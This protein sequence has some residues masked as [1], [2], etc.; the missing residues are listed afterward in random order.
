M[1]GAGPLTHDSGFLA[2]SPDP[3]DVTASRLMS[4]TGASA[5]ATRI[6]L[7]TA[8]ASDALRQR[9]LGGRNEAASTLA[10]HALDPSQFHSPRANTEAATHSDSIPQGPS[11][12][13]LRD[14]L[15][16]EFCSPSGPSSVSASHNRQGMYRNEMPPHRSQ[17]VRATPGTHSGTITPEYSGREMAPVQHQHTAPV[18]QHSLESV[19]RS[20]P[21]PAPSLATAVPAL[22]S[23][24]QLQS[25]SSAN[26]FQS[27]D[28]ESLRMAS[29]ASGSLVTIPITTVPQ[30]HAHETQQQAPGRGTSSQPSAMPERSQE[31]GSTTQMHAGVE[32][33]ARGEP[34]RPAVNNAASSQTPRPAIPPPPLPCVRTRPQTRTPSPLPPR[35]AANRASGTRGATSSHASSRHSGHAA[36]TATA[37]DAQKRRRQGA[38]SYGQD[39]SAPFQPERSS[40]SHCRQGEA[41]TSQSPRPHVRRSP[42]PSP[43][44]RPRWALAFSAPRSQ[45][46]NQPHQPVQTNANAASTSTSAT[47]RYNTPRCSLPSARRS[48]SCSPSSTPGSDPRS[49]AK[50]GAPGVQVPAG[51]YT[52]RTSRSSRGTQH[53]APGNN[54]FG[55]AVHKMNKRRVSTPRSPTKGG[56][57]PSQIPTAAT[58]LRLPRCSSEG[59]EALADHMTASSAAK[60]TPRPKTRSGS[61]YSTPRGHSVPRNMAHGQSV[62][63]HTPREQPVRPL[64]GVGGGVKRTSGV[65]T[66]RD[67]VPGASTTEAQGTADAKGHFSPGTFRVPKHGSMP[68]ISDPISQQYSITPT[69]SVQSVGRYPAMQ[70]GGSTGTFSF[71]VDMSAQGSSRELRAAR[72]HWCDSQELRFC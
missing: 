31:P 4:R 43:P 47:S 7:P 52:P 16:S 26:I 27:R 37:A 54:A 63:R 59:P 65:K 57:P 41:T 68:D 8:G 23:A 32:I 60:R 40:R 21:T 49:P 62:P 50:P 53:T 45:P 44:V 70:S 55:S 58:A 19:H 51:T 12:A 24:H 22:A 14:N 39:T 28:F 17:A 72:Q 29:K 67:R 6:V 71:P 34:H 61:S 33:A 30:S 3:L 42:A 9:G 25:Q 2:D 35:R 69:R 38:S 36:S 20:A 18:M 46:S 1:S 64:W 5:A 11:I 15:T 56:C 66:A 10:S 13:A 48:T